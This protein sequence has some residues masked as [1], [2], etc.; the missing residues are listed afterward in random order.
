MHT[1]KKIDEDTNKPDSVLFYNVTKG[2][3]DTVDHLIESFSCRR[4]TNRWTFNILMYLLDVA[5]HN[6]V[7]LF[8]IKKNLTNDKRLRRT[9][10][11]S[12]AINLM[13]PYIEYRAEYYSINNVGIKS[14]LIECFKRCGF[15]IKKEQPI[16]TKID[17]KRHQCYLCIGKDSKHSNICSM[18]NNTVCKN[19][20]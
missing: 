15:T 9:E 20:C 3:V 17:S 13:K 14:S 8:K 4:E 7:C 2:G 19:H 12:L 16:K 11:Q 6:A 10:L 1:I 5:A 18:C